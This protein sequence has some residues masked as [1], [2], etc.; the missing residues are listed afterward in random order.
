MIRTIPDSI[1]VATKPS[2]SDS[3]NELDFHF[4]VYFHNSIMLWIVRSYRHAELHLNALLLFRSSIEQC[5][6]RLRK[7]SFHQTIQYAWNIVN[8]GSVDLMFFSSFAVSSH[9]STNGDHI[10]VTFGARSATRGI[11]THQKAAITINIAFSDHL[12]EIRFEGFRGRGRSTNGQYLHFSLNFDL[13]HNAVVRVISIEI[14]GVKNLLSSIWPSDWSTRANP[15]MKGKSKL[16]EEMFNFVATVTPTLFDGVCNDRKGV[17]KK[18]GIKW[19]RGWSKRRNYE[20][21]KENISRRW[22]KERWKSNQNQSGTDS[23]ATIISHF[24][25]SKMFL[26]SSRSK[27]VDP[28]SN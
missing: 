2:P 19:E 24:F 8:N 25:T 22:Q 12:I 20:L 13:I 21:G 4:F 5:S 17:E 27:L 28:S 6:V 15:I 26:N 7:E 3:W 23:Y 16:V 9:Y 14:W 18:A 1:S 11:D 10:F